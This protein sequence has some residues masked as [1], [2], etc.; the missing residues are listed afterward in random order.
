MKRPTRR[1]HSH[2]GRKAENKTTAV[3]C[4]KKRTT[5]APPYRWCRNRVQVRDQ[6]LFL[7]DVL[8]AKAF[9]RHK[10]AAHRKKLQY[11]KRGQRH[12][13]AVSRALGKEIRDCQRE[14]EISNKRSRVEC[15]TF[16]YI[17]C[18]VCQRR[19]PAHLADRGS[20]KCAGVRFGLAMLYADIESPISSELIIDSEVDST[21]IKQKKDHVNSDTC[22]Q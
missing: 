3:R 1:K 16:L 22:I 8:F 6:A 19:R 11:L 21:A 14:A 4:Q 7:R 9:Y 13:Y 18:E 12:F 10:G 17:R 2:S 15:H 20:W 5:A